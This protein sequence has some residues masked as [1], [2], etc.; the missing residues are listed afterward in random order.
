[1]S[2]AQ[3]RI[4]IVTPSYNQA[5][6]VEATV[7]SVFDQRYPDLEYIFMDGGSKDDTVARL[8]PYRER[9]AHFQS[10]PDDGQAAAIAAGFERATG[11]IMGYLNS[12]DV[13]LPG[14][15]N[16]VAGYF[17][18]HPEVDFIYGHRAIIDERAVVRGHWILPN[19]SNFLMRRWDLIPQESCFWRRALLE[20][21]GNVD[22]KMRFAMDYDLFVR[23]MRSGRF[24]RVNR[25]LAAFRIHSTSKTS[26]L[27]YTI[28]LQ[29]IAQ[30][31]NTYG[32][33]LYSTL[34]G[35]AFMVSV[36]ARSALFARR[37]SVLP[38]LPPSVGYNLAE[39]W[40]ERSSVSTAGIGA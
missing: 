34:I 15:L 12:D 37:G 36:Q 21:E 39:V 35:K 11:E 25:F 30:V 23:F 5:Q 4:S 22:P 20:R 2:T 1:M 28:G 27:L 33:R 9:F 6:Y 32:L 10:A 14:T 26:S 40:G 3:P 7:R 29:E 18:R 13:L 16:F 31:H 38:G 17:A 8:A 19:H 24:R